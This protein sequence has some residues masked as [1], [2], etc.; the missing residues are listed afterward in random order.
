MNL[1]TEMFVF[2]NQIHEGYTGT[3]FEDWLCLQN[4]NEVPLEVELRFHLESGEVLWEDV[5]L[6]PLSR[7]TIYVNTMIP[8]QEGVAF[9]IHA[10]QE[11]IVE[12]PLYFRYKGAWIGGHVS[13]GY[14]PGVGR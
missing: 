3:G 11:V 14:A 4:P 10:P 8:Y 2:S 13:S 7:T 12:R 1:K 6:P 9:S 5:T